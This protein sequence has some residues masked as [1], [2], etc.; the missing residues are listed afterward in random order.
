VVQAQSTS[1]G[2]GQHEQTLIGPLSH[3]S[4]DTC[5]RANGAMPLTRGT[6][7]YETPPQAEPCHPIGWKF[8][9]IAASI[10]IGMLMLQAGCQTPESPSPVDAFRSTNERHVAMFGNFELPRKLGAVENV[11]LQIPTIS[12]DGT[13]MLYLRTNRESLSPMTLLGSPDPRDTPLE[14]T[15]EIWIRPVG[16][17]GPGRR[18]SDERWAHS[19][20][21]SDSGR[22]IAYVVN[23]PPASFIVHLDLADTEKRIL[24]V[25]DAI[26]CLPRFDGSDDALLFCAGDD[27]NGPFR[28]YRQT[29]RDDKPVSLTPKGMDCFL[30]LASDANGN[31]FCARAEGNHMNWVRCGPHGVTD[32]VQ[33]CG[34][35]DR[36]NLLQTWAGVSAPLSPDRRSW[37]FYDAARNSI[38]AY[39]TTNQRIVRHRQGTITACW[40]ADDAIALA[41]S[42]WIFVVNTTT[43]MSPQLLNGPW[44]PCRYV[45]ATRR[46][47]LL[48]K[49]NVRRFSIV[50]VVFKPR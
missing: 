50:E 42:D 7:A 32:V 34:P 3:G 40:L 25:P 35:S 44:I 9:E 19:P 43:G 39:H 16:G 18:L 30:P 12:P 38:T 36:P 5:F 47:L 46:L 31:V 14:D 13:Q 4:A 20:I 49:E 41:Q 8:A 2:T 21:W 6:T 45:P 17:T 37:L 29:I 11:N 26:N 15:L 24:G 48:G 27:P 22:A 23:E 10:G 33:Q 28:V 1:G